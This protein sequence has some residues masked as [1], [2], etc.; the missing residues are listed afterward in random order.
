VLVL[1]AGGD[2]L[3]AL[4]YSFLSGT[5]AMLIVGYLIYLFSKLSEDGNINMENALL[6]TG[7]VYLTIPEEESGQGKIHITVNNS[8]REINAV[9]KN[10]LPLPTGSRIR[11]IEIIDDNLLL[12]EPI[13]DLL[14]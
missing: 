2:V 13:E 6:N 14:E 4:G 5:I 12:V 9:T 3:T 8:F 1:N 11:V 7:E 10:S